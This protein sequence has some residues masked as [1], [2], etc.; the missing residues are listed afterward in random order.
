MSPIGTLALQTVLVLAAATVLTLSALLLIEALA[1]LWPVKP[2]ALGARRSEVPR[3]VVLMPAHD[4]AIGLRATLEPILRDLPANYH[5]VVIADN[6][7]DSTAAIARAAGATVLERQDPSLRGKGYAMD[8]GL[9]TLETQM[10]QPP[11]VVI[12]L[13]ADCEISQASLDLL[14]SQAMVTGRPIQAVYLMGS[15]PKPNPKHLVSAFAFKVKN[16]VRPLGLSR[17]GL[18]SMLMGTGMAVIWLKI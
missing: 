15:P 5:M 11:D 1:A 13:D 14:V 9:R 7:S 18:P 16:L 2:V 17:F 8:F 10:A 6:C 12:F 3:V 4:E